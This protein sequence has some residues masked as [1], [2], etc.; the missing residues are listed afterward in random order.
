MCGDRVR[1]ALFGPEIFLA[2]DTYTCSFRSLAY[3]ELYLTLATV[4]RRFELE[5]FET[6]VDYAWLARDFFVGVPKLDSKGIGTVVA[7]SLEA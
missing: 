7:S 1:W 4:M 3:A 6:A 5:N 2:T